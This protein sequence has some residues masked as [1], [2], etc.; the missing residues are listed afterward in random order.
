MKG[1]L[2][3]S[4][5]LIAFAT[6]LDLS[7]N[8]KNNKCQLANVRV[9][10]IRIHLRP[11]LLLQKYSR[12]GSFGTPLAT[13]EG[14]DIFILVSLLSFVLDRK[15]HLAHVVQSVSNT[16]CTFRLLI[17]YCAKCVLSYCLVTYSSINTRLWNSTQVYHITGNVLI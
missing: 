4:I 15:M 13:T 10:G 7:L 16:C 11:I 2:C 9:D 12:L 14:G 8:E 6:L 17:A 1:N 3:Q 5:F